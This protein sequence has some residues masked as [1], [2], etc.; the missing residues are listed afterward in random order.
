MSGGALQ[1]FRQS[2]DIDYEKW[3]DGVGYDL[4]AIDAFDDRDRRE[5]EKLLVPRAAQD[6]RDLEALDRLGTP[7]A[8][9]AILKTR[10]HK[11]PETRLRAHDYGPPP[12]QAEWDAV[13]TYAWP[14]VEPY[15]G[16]TLAKRC[17]MEHPSQAVVAAVWKQVREPSVNAYHA[18]ET[19]CLIAGII[20]H[21][22]DF[23]YREI[24]LRLNG[25]RT[26]DRDLAVAQV[27]ALCR[28]GLARYVRG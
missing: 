17:S 16:L 24:Y 27:E 14:H 10:K 11:N 23:T 15:S 19:L 1:R 3:H 21:E 28:D 12:T 8:V 13:L 7:R 5:A 20:P 9:D 18:A 25:P 2:M 6:W 22:Y 26:D 4:E